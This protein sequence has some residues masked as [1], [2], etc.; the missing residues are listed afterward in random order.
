MES[1]GNERR[2]KSP[3]K[4]E[5]FVPFYSLLIIKQNSKRQ[6]KTLYLGRNTNLRKCAREILHSGYLL[7]HH[8]FSVF[9]FLCNC[10]P[11][12][13]YWCWQHDI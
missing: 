10:I 11:M 8:P 13:S 4:L 2:A 7:H 9:F 6:A 5:D 1:C 12:R 3:K